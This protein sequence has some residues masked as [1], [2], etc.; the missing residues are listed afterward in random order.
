MPV[1]SVAGLSDRANSSF[2]HFFFF[3]ALSKSFLLILTS[4]SE[5]L[6]W[7]SPAVFGSECCQNL[8]N[9]LSPVPGN[10][11][12]CRA[13]PALAPREPQN[14]CKFES[15]A[16]LEKDSS[17]SVLLG[18]DGS[19]WFLIYFYSALIRDLSFLRANAPNLWTFQAKC[20]KEV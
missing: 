7:N 6:L 1:I 8:G 5:L 14:S 16:D 3:K 11:S 9:S 20:E 15:G 12:H 2:N 10:C 19:C 18:L 17:L 4:H 13:D